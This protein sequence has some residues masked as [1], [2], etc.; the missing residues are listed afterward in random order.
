[1]S[2]IADAMNTPAVTALLLSKWE[3]KGY[4]KISALSTD[5]RALTAERSYAA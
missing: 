5:P 1:M 2:L 3:M 4:T